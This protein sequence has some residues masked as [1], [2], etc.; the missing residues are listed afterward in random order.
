MKA[1]GPHWLLKL[2]A[3]LLLAL[4]VLAGA[5]GVARLVLGAPPPPPVAARVWSGEEVL[6]PQG[7]RLVPAFQ[8]RFQIAPFSPAPAPGTLRVIALG[9]SSV[10][11]GEIPVADEFPDRVGAHLATPERPVEALNLGRPAVDSRAMVRIVQGLADQGVQAHLALVYLGHND[12]GN[13]T[14]ERQWRARSAERALLGRQLDR[15]RLGF[16]LR[17]VLGRGS[18]SGP[19]P[20]SELP[21]LTPQERDQ[22]LSELGANLS[23][24]VEGLQG[25]GMA[26]ALIPAIS[27]V[28]T[29]GPIGLQ[30]PEELPEG[31]YEIAAMRVRYHP[32]RAPLSSIE[33]ALERAP[34]CAAL[35]Y[36]RGR[37][38]LE[39]GDPRAHLD[40]LAS[41]DLDPVAMRAT[42]AV[43]QTIREA[44]A[45]TGATLVD[46]P[47]W[48]QRH[49][50]SAPPTWFVDE[51]HMNPEGHEAVARII[52]EQVRPLLEESQ[53]DGD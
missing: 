25:L 14:Q 10:H 49:H 46:L 1:S 29:Y 7:E 45:A 8:G 41:R 38:R 5:E 48:V 22:A 37:H 17:R 26:V 28:Q 27:D 3:G 12:L 43:Q 2:G 9:G 32:R 44:A 16:E 50:G 52:A 47:A 35:L 34:D 13:R 18:A 21:A 24:V 30:C 39:Q 6:V 23:Q 53:P 36:L 31:S 15:L 33:G 4:L 11:I 42:S 40:L 20:R 19:V 51:A